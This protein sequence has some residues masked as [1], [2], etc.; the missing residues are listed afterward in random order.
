LLWRAP[1]SESR[2][3]AACPLADLARRYGA[4]GGQYY[5]CPI[6]FNSKQLDAA[7]LI[8]GAEL[9]G[10]TP[11]WAWIGDDGATTFSY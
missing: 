8:A 5:V 11:M 10:T 7:S 6:C 3:T 2:A 9:Q 1:R 4:A